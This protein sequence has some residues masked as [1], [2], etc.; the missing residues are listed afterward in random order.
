MQTDVMPVVVN[1]CRAK[2]VVRNIG[3][4]AIKSLPVAV[5]LHR[6]LDASQNGTLL[7]NAAVGIPPARQLRVNGIAMPRRK[8]GKR[9]I[10]LG[11]MLAKPFIIFW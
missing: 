11:K 6:D 10:N 7:C 4:E 9:R 5:C 3:K 2:D 1:P 8:L